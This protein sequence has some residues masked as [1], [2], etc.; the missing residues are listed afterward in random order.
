MKAAGLSHLSAVSGAN[1]AMVLGAAFALCRLFGVPRLPTLLLGLAALC[2]FVLLVGYEPSVLRAA[3][4]GAIAAFSVHSLRGRNG[5]R[6]YAS[7]WSSC[8]PSTP[9]LRGRP[10][11]SSPLSSAGIVLIGRRLADKLARWLPEF[12]AEGT[13]IAVAAQIACLPVLV[14]LSPS[15]SLYSVPPTCWLPR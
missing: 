14:A 15:F 5:L 8:W 10:R 2:G 6:R 11:S 7:R 12:L 3:V 4:M 9:I 1:C 13:A